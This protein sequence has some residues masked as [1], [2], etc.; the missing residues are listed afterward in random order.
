MKKKR[1]DELSAAWGEQPC[2]H[3]ELSKEYDLGV[4]TGRYRCTQCGAAF[5]YREK[6]E[7]AAKRRG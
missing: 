2:D 5:T 6:A 7:L 1:A 4:Q 3:P